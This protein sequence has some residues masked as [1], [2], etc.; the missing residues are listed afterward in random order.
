MQWHTKLMLTIIAALGLLSLALWLFLQETQGSLYTC[1]VNAA[2]AQ[3]AWRAAQAE[4]QT[5][6]DALGTQVGDLR[7]ELDTWRSRVLDA[8][9]VTREILRTV[10]ERLPPDCRACV[11]AYEL[12][13]RYVN[14]GPEPPTDTIVVSV[15]DVLGLNQASWQLD[16]PRLCP[17]CPPLPPPCPNVVMPVDGDRL[18][19]VAELG[20]GYGIAGP[21]IDAGLYPLVYASRKYEI[22]LGGRGHV[23]LTD[24]GDVFGNA[25]LEVRLGR[26]GFWK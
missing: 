3:V 16:M 21:E 15:R 13:R 10:V 24:Q 7:T 6:I 5:R 2:D 18:R 26:K 19:M 11:E 20:L 9:T 14:P 12:D 8:D 4:A 1:Q 17:T 23:T 22:R 25:L